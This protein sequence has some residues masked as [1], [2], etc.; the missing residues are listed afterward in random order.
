[1]VTRHLDPRLGAILQPLDKLAEWVS[2]QG[3]DKWMKDRQFDPRKEFYKQAHVDFG[4]D[5]FRKL[6][7]ELEQVFKSN[8]AA[9]RPLAVRSMAK[10][11][12]LS[13]D[14]LPRL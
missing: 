4:S 6:D 2:H 13:S 3:R 7:A 12:N 9:L 1:M 14:G 10:L 8:E 11:G 5:D